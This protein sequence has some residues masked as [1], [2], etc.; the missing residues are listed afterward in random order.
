MANLE[1]ELKN[2]EEGLRRLK[3]EYH[4]F[5]NGNRKKPPE[6]L[7]FSL[8]RLA[9][10]LSERA[11]MTPAQR[12]RYTTLLTRFYTY[13]NLWRRMLQEREKGKE[14]KKD[15]ATRSTT[16]S[17]GKRGSIEKFRISITDAGTEENKVKSLYETLTRLKKEG[18]SKESPVPF[19][20]FAKYI[21]AQTHDIRNKYGCASVA[22]IIAMEEGTIRFTAAAEKP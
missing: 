10:Q 7:R 20:Q 18:N 19:P 14:P 9:K 13:R 22:Y 8:E 21:A 4:I 1:E 3:I 16:P 2:M 17:R 11:G 6:D 5:F 12:F 15:K